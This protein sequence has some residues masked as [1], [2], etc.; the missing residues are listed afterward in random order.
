MFWFALVALM[1]AIAAP[2][3][4]YAAPP[5]GDCLNGACARS[6]SSIPAGPIRGFAAALA[7]PERA[8]PVRGLFSNVRENRAERRQTRQANRGGCR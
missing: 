8:A 5:S 6:V 4:L 7:G 3:K 1:L 2:E